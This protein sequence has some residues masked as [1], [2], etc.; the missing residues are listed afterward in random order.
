[1]EQE[2]IDRINFLAAKKKSEGLSAS[3]LKEQEELRAEYIK[4]FK[5]KTKQHLLNIKVVDKD[6]ND[7][8]P[9]KLKKAKKERDL[10]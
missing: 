10:S 2:K 1:M 4:M 3:E 7:I 9:E 8:T 6:G 5:D